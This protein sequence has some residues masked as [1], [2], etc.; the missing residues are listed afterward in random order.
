MTFPPF[1]EPTHLYF[2]TATMIKWKH[3]FTKPEYINIPLN[4][5][6]RMQKQKRILPLSP[7]Y[8]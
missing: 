2:I 5:L 7:Y 6:A 8:P 1:H 3:L 4:S